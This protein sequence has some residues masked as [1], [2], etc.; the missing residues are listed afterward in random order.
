MAP[1]LFTL[2]QFVRLILLL[3]FDCEYQDRFDINWNAILTTFYE[4]LS[5]DVFD[6]DARNRIGGRGDGRTHVAKVVPTDEV[7]F[8]EPLKANAFTNKIYFC[9]CVYKK[10]F[11]TEN[12]SEISNTVCRNTK[13]VSVTWIFMLNLYIESVSPEHTYSNYPVANILKMINQ[14]KFL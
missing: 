2:L 3:L 13:T 6:I 11:G 4:N 9:Y 7:G 1:V 10:E 12:C 8:L 14:E 5:T